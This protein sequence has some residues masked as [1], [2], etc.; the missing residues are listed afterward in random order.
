MKKIL[1]EIKIFVFTL[2]FIVFMSIP[3]IAE[4]GSITVD[5]D[6][7]ESKQSSSFAT[8]SGAPIWNE[9]LFDYPDYNH[10]WNLSIKANGHVTYGYE[11]NITTSCQIVSGGSGTCVVSYSK[12]LDRI[13]YVFSSDTVITSS[14][15]VLS[16]TPNITKDIY[17]TTKANRTSGQTAVGGG[18]P[19]LCVNI[20]RSD[21]AGD[22]S[23]F[24]GDHVGGGAATYEYV[25]SSASIIRYNVNYFSSPGGISFT[26][27]IDKSLSAVN[28]LVKVHS[29][30]FNI[31]NETTFNTNNFS[32]SYFYLDGLYINASIASG[33]YNDALINGTGA[34]G[35]PSVAP[36]TLPVT[37]TK[38]STGAN[39]VLDKSE[40]FVGDNINITWYY[41]DGD[42]N[43]F[44]SSKRLKIEENGNTFANGLIDLSSQTGFYIFTSSQVGSFKAIAQ[45]CT[46][47]IICSDIG[48]DTAMINPPGNSWIALTNST[49]IA[50]VPFNVTYH[51]GYSTSSYPAG[52]IEIRGIDKNTGNRVD[53]VLPSV[54]PDGEI[55]MGLIHKFTAGEYKIELYDA[56]K[57]TVMDKKDLVV[58]NAPT[59]IPTLNITISNISMDKYYYFVNDFATITYAVDD[60]N[61]TNY[62]IRADVV[63]ANST[64]TTKSFIGQLSEQIGQFDTLINNFQ[65]QQT[66]KCD[67]GLYCY[68]DSGINFL[69]MIAYNSTNSQVISNYTF[70]VSSTTTDGYGLKVSKNNVTVGE[71]FTVTTIVPTGQTAMLR[72]EDPGYSTNKISV[73]NQTVSEGTNTFPVR[74]TRV[75]S[76]GIGYYDV[77]L[78]SGSIIKVRASITVYSQAQATTTTSTGF[79]KANDIANLIDSNL[80]WALMFTV[81]LMIAVAVASRRRDE[82]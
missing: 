16:Y 9:L 22:D 81:G 15:V 57:N 5:D 31:F 41:S 65:G 72:I 48:Y 67:Q 8:M 44:L 46:L 78:Y 38:P 74:I 53:T 13:N 34:P 2:I 43:D 29:Q 52:I 50:K 59:L 79:Q 62:S 10:I 36:G 45:K 14:K 26:L 75:G 47:I 24:F 11:S 51:I 28:S 39:V 76:G 12:Y 69:R 68:F 20:A 80:F 21:L 17:F 19:S 61:Y 32:T 33:V 60:V 77:D 66:L 54:F 1:Y 25:I 56:A 35:T 40:Y 18:E 58:V 49:V 7:Y 6:V 3:V 71:T 23:C 63:N 42:W 4:T 73:F 37:V 27:D 70:F 82:E 64:A 55:Q 30:T